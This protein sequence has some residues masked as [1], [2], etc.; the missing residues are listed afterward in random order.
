MKVLGGWSCEIGTSTYDSISM[1]WIINA[2]GGKG[3]KG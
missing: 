1:H 3:L 2:A